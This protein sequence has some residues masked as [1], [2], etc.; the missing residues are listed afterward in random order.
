MP[1]RADVEMLQNAIGNV[2]N[3]FERN[4]QF[5][6]EQEQAM[7]RLA[8]EQQMRSDSQQHYAAENQHFQNEEDE[9]KARADQA[10]K[11]KVT[12][13]LADP[14]NPESGMEFTGTPEQLQT[15]MTNSA[16][17]GKP[18]QQ[19]ASTPQKDFA[20]TYKIGG[21][22]YS[23]H[24]KEAA[25]NF[26]AGMKAKGIDVNDPKYAQSSGG[27]TNAFAQN[28]DRYQQEL[29]AA[30]SA[31]TPE[32]KN[33]HLDNAARY[34]A[35]LDKQGQFKP[36]EI[37]PEKNETKTGPNGEILGK[38]QVVYGIPAPSAT[39]PSDSDLLQNMGVGQPAGA[40]P[41]NFDWAAQG[42]PAPAPVTPTAALTAP[43]SMTSPTQPVAQDGTATTLPNP[44]RA[45]AKSYVKKYGA[46]AKQQLQQDGFDISRYSD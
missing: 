39:S 26:E 16:Q 17:Q 40:S 15:I 8:L 27:K 29:D 42:N 46:N 31:Q 1:N 11:P 43:P 2:G 13:Y 30:E 6:A 22:I 9:G 4:R 37:P 28:S 5:K 14:K 12:T 19:F 7:Q 23:F 3:T 32:E 45:I 21:S 44:T 20:A 25:D 33:I 36:P 41:S 24:S 35:W 10:A 38:T 18:L 34:K